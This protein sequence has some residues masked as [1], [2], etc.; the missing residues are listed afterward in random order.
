MIGGQGA[1]LEHVFPMLSTSLLPVAGFGHRRRGGERGGKAYCPRQRDLVV[2]TIEL[3]RLPV[4][5]E[6]AR[7]A[8]PTQPPRLCH[9]TAAEAGRGPGGMALLS[10][11]DNG[12]DVAG[13]LQN[14]AGM[15]RRNRA[16]AAAGGDEGLGDDLLA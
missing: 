13:H 4:P 11:A 9:K 6:D 14:L 2:A 3:L 1:V 10:A 12:G 8:G 5:P 15:V 7:G 16:G